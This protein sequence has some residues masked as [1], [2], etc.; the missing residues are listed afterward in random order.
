MS[1]CAYNEKLGKA[2][3]LNSQGTDTEEEIICIIPCEE[4]KVIAIYEG[5]L[6]V[7]PLDS[8][9]YEPEI[10]KFLG[11]PQSEKVLCFYE[12]TCGT[13][14]YTEQSG[15]CKFLLIKNKSGHIGFPKGHIE[16]NETEEETALREVFEETGFNVIISENFRTQYEYVTLENTHKTC[17]YFLARYSFAPAKIQESEILQSWLVSFDEAMSLLNF[18]QDRN[19]LEK[20]QKYLEIQP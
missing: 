8:V 1:N 16:L 14:M 19:I 4:G 5:K 6:I 17:V 18:A 3:T 9:I 11:I 10:K 7:A 12:K 2:V 20:V 13:V 15:E